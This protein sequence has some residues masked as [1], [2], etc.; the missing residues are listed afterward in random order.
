MEKNKQHFGTKNKGIGFDIDALISLD[1]SNSCSSS[2]SSS[3][4]KGEK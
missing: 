2:T 3:G 1:S 4:D